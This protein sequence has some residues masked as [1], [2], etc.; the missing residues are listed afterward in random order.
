MEKKLKVVFVGTPDMAPICL[1]RLL[2]RDFNIVC[3]VPPKKSHETYSFFK[4]F[5]E[6]KNVKLEDFEKDVN[7]KSF[8]E[9][10]KSYGADIGVVCSYDLKLKK[11][12]LA[13]TRLGYLNCHPS[14]L[15]NYR[16]AMP[17]FHIIKNG[18]KKSA[19]TIHF[20]DENFDTGDIVSQK[21]FELLPWETTGTLFSRT[22]YMLADMLCDTLDEL[23]KSGEVKRIKQKEGDYIKA[24]KV[25]HTV[26]INWSKTIYE[27]D[28]LI[29]ACNPFFDA[30]TIFRNVD[31]KILK[32]TPIEHRNHGL[33]TG[34][35][36]RS[37]ANGILV[38]ACDGYISLDMVNMGNW[39]NFGA[40]EFFYTFSPKEK[41]VLE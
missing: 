31:M 26:K 9:K 40:K 27:I 23:E 24:P 35:I 10:I 14:M 2:E 12:F 16:G 5:V 8:V 25:E 30:V 39:G 11:E 19:V 6:Y 17:Y 41:E 3:V 37:S 7:E 33:K 34:T 1:E 29:R 18:E 38:A 15:P 20:V 32:A 36:A 21:E 13:T 22:N 4:G 28:S